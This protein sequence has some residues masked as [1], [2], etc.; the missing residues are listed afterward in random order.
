MNF[1]IFLHF[2][3]K[4]NVFLNPSLGPA[5]KSSFHDECMDSASK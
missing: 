5:P 1:S 3:S 2:V 4:M